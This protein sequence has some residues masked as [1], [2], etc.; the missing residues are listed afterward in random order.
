MNKH[1]P[2]VCK[3]NNIRVCVNRCVNQRQGGA[4][5]FNKLFF[6][7]LKIMFFQ[8]TGFCVNHCVNHE[9]NN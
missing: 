1:F 9:Y 8:Q 7:R 6:N 2:A 4:W 5:C 3:K